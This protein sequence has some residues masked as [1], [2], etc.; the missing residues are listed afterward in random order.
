MINH[1][2]SIRYDTW[3]KVLIL[4]ISLLLVALNIDRMFC[5]SMT[6]DECAPHAYAVLPYHDI[7]SFKWASSNVHILNSLSRKFFIEAFSDTPFWRRAGSLVAQ[8]CYLPF[9]YLLCRRL[10]KNGAWQV[11]VFLLLNLH[12]FLFE[13]WGLSRGYGMAIAATLISVY[14]FLRYHDGD[15]IRWLGLS[16][17]TAILAVYANFT[18]LDYY[19]GLVAVIVLR[20]CLYPRR[21]LLLK[22]A[23]SIILASAVLSLLVA[24][25]IL[26]LIRTHELYYGGANNFI[27]DTVVSLIKENFA[28]PGPSDTPLLCTIAT[29]GVVVSAIAG[30]W[31]IVRYV[32]EKTDPAVLTGLLLWLLLAV[33]VFATIAQHL[34]LGTLY[35]IDRTALFLIPL[36]IL[37]LTFWLGHMSRRA[38]LLR[39]LLLYLFTLAV[40]VNFLQ[41][42]TLSVTRVWWFDVNDL[43]V[44]DR[45][46]KETSTRPG[47]SKVSVCSLFNPAFHY[48]T[49]TDKRYAP[50]FEPVNVFTDCPGPDDT[51]FD[52]YYVPASCLH[53]VPSCYV[54]DTSFFSAFFLFRKNNIPAAP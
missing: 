30:I 53:N 42:I 12:P 51:T 19:M 20:E 5:V 39:S 52:Y 22:K 34:L 47:K 15:K 21:Q 6:F 35:P 41:H 37:S 4:V 2:R 18:L 29:I 43:A 49:E 38:A 23:L 48:Y 8:L 31:W 25:P 3:V 40:T 13:F 7:F 16:L 9:C 50:Y 54:P 24:R 17:G 36:F 46:K 10:F 33:P 11:C 1:N 28:I 27:K 14:S 32:K 26:Q 44:L 45:I